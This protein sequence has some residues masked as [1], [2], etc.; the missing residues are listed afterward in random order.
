MLRIVL[1]L[2][3]VLLLIVLVPRLLSHSA[4]P[5][6]GA[7]APDFTLPSQEGSSV[8]LKDY[9]G[10]WVVLYFYPKDQT[11]GCSREA[12]NF[13]ADQPK[14]SEHNAVV[15]GVSLDSVDSHKKFCAKEGLNFKLLADT[16]HKVTDSYGSLTNLGVVKFAAR[17]TF[18]IDPSGKIAKVYTSVDPLK[19]SGEV[20][21]ELDGLQKS[22]AVKR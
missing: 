6:E 13:Q 21:A 2:A 10:N 22:E 19:H 11:P 8:S 7:S 17:H 14:Y 5:T 4:T 18:L 3:V 1:L 9:R 16:D 20:L 12:H 15:L